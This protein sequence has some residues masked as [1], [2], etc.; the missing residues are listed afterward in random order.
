MALGR[1]SYNGSAPPVLP[2]ARCMGAG[3]HG[4]RRMLHISRLAALCAPPSI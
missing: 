4:L 3:M 2:S 1:R